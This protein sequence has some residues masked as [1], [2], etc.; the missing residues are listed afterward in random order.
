MKLATYL[1]TRTSTEFA[2]AVGVSL[3]LVSLWRRGLRPVPLARCLQIESLT[4]GVV[5]AEH[6]RPDVKW[7]R[8]GRWKR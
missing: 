2:K 1:K 5:R 6:L 4:G 7:A 3:S 8:S